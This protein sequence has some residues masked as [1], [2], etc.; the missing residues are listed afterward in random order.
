MRLLILGLSIL[1]SIGLL[2]N[3]YSSA[4]CPDYIV[5]NNIFCGKPI[6]EIEQQEPIKTD[7]IS[8][9]GIDR[10][11]NLFKIYCEG[12]EL[13]AMQY[14]N[15]S[16][17]QNEIPPFFTIYNIQTTRAEDPILQAMIMKETKKAERFF[18]INFGNFNN[19]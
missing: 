17:I 5:P 2:N 12:Q 13:L 14:F 18:S 1:L 19:W 11:S 15:S 7:P 9:Q 10:N 6:I 3:A 16:E 4:V 8:S